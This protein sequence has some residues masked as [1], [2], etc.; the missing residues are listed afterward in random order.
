MQILD[1][2]GNSL[3]QD[4]STIMNDSWLS[5]TLGHF[6]ASMKHFYP[7]KFSSNTAAPYEAG[8]VINFQYAKLFNELEKDHRFKDYVYSLLENE[9]YKEMQI[10]E[11]LGVMR[12]IINQ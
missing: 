8:N 5:R 1:G 11:H 6:I 10:A 2:K 12:F 9:D 3:S 7:D 4:L